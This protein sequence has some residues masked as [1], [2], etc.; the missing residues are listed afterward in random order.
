MNTR[1]FVSILILVL[2]V[3][4]IA[5]SCATSKKS[6]IS[7]DT[8]LNELTGI[9]Y[10]EEYEPSTVERIPQVTVFSDGSIE[11]YKEHAVLTTPTIHTGNFISIEEAWSD[12]KGNIWYQAR[13]FRSNLEQTVN[14]FGKI[15][16]SGKIW[17]TVWSSNDFP[18]KIETEN[19]NY[20]IYY[21][22]E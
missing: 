4:I 20:L 14:Q 17:E 5:G 19:F 11:F 6:Y 1:A 21:R 12:S 2:A 13:V 15:S 16:N 3:L 9:W 10:N 22:Q 18:N 8:I 7:T